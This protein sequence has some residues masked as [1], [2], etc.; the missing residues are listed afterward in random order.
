MSFLNGIGA[1]AGAAGGANAAASG[2]GH[3]LGADPSRISDIA[4]NIGRGMNGIAAAGGA[5]PG[6]QAAEAP[7]P[8]A[9][10]M[11]LLDDAVLQRLVAQF[12]GGQPGYAR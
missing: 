4:G 12:S 10:H 11:Q 2:L 6:Y 9:N 5:E 8:P 1:A 7:A 3:M